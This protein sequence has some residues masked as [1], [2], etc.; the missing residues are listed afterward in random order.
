MASPDAIDTVL[1]AFVA[2]GFRPIPPDIAAT[3]EVWILAFEGISDDALAAATR[4]YLVDCDDTWWPVPAE[5]WK[6]A[7]HIE[8]LRRQ[9]P[10]LRLVDDNAEAFAEAAEELRTREPYAEFPSK[11]WMERW[12]R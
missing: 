1:Q 9:P 8:H 10:Q 4:Q 6:I 7:T 2:A 12:G 5:V 3:S 11:G